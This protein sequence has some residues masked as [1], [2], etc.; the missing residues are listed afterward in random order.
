MIGMVGDAPLL[1]DELSNALTGP[2]IAREA[3]G[4]GSLGEPSGKLEFLLFAQAGWRAGGG[5]FTQRLGS[6]FLGAGQPP[7]DG[8]LGDAQSL[9]D[10]C[11]LPAAVVEF[12][13]AQP[14]AFAPVG[15]RL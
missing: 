1:P 15:G 9:S 7:A 8:A 2:D 6:L 10:L 11:L 14:S 3:E 13:G 4:L 12:Q 5:A